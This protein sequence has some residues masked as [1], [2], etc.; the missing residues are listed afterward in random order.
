M[1]RIDEIR[2]GIRISGTIKVG[3]DIK[4]G[5]VVWN[6]RVVTIKRGNSGKNI[7]VKIR[8]HCKVYFTIEWLLFQE[9]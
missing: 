7:T 4:V 8:R 6:D 5:R 2:G 9:W 1:N 3:R